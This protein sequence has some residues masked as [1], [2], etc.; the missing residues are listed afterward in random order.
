VQEKALTGYRLSPQQR[1]LWALLQHGWNES[2]QAKCA[3][4]IRGR[5]ESH[6]LKSAA[7]NVIARHE[8][9]RTTF[10]RLP[11][12]AIPMQVIE[13]TGRVCGKRMI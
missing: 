12:M 4:M 5:L 7:Q 11:G 8:I 3:V 13:E 10:Q 9:L 1:R 6:R 2:Y